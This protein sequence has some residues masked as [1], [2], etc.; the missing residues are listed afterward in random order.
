MKHSRLVIFPIPLLIALT[1]LLLGNGT[2]QANAMSRISFPNLHKYENG[3]SSRYVITNTGYSDGMLSHDFVSSDSGDR[4]SMMDT[5]QA[6]ESKVYDLGDISILP[7]GFSG[8]VTVS[9]DV[10]ITGVVLPG[11]VPP[12][13]IIVSGVA[14]STT[15]VPNRYSATI[16]PITTTLPITVVWNA[17]DQEPIVRCI[18]LL[19]DVVTF[20]WDTPGT[21]MVTVTAINLSG[22]VTDSINVIIYAKVKADFVAS[23]TVGKNPL[24]VMFSN[25]SEGDFVSNLWDFGDGFTSTALH[26][27]H[28]YSDTGSYTVT[29]LIEGNGG[30]DSEI[31]PNFIKVYEY[32]SYLPLIRR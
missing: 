24:T 29:L 17:T 7:D 3:I 9:A 5:I 18:E 1:F 23:P 4:Y 31:K 22:I 12:T 20:T 28:V 25:E 32:Q 30:V 2:V 15:D 10:P 16:T 19:T 8:I 11:P 26:P 6:G 27:V 21:K 13:G 14:T